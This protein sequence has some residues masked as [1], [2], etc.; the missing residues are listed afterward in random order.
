[1]FNIA[2]KRNKRKYEATSTVA[3]TTCIQCIVVPWKIPR[4]IEN[5][6][7]LLGKYLRNN[8]VASI[9]QFIDTYFYKE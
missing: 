6:S 9:A 7:I 8:Q 3:M 1:V 4:S 2:I 5:F